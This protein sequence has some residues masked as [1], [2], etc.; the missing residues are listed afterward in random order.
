MPAHFGRCRCRLVQVP[1]EIAERS[2]E[3]LYYENFYSIKQNVFLVT[4]ISFKGQAVFCSKNIVPD[5]NAFLLRPCSV[6]VPFAFRPLGIHYR[7]AA[8]VLN[9]P[10]GT[11]HKIERNRAECGWNANGRGRKRNAF[12]S[13]K[14]FLL[15]IY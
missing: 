5:T 8:Y 3:T 9:A 12:V 14:I 4:L 6:S 10:R 2:Q 1:T 7:P 13:G 11:G 15:H